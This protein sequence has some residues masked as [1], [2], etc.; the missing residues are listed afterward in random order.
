MGVISRTST[1][2][3][4]FNST[5]SKRPPIIDIM[6]DRQI[7]KLPKTVFYCSKC[8]N[9][10][11]RPRLQFDENRVCDACN[12]SYVKDHLI[13]WKKREEELLRLLDKYRSKDGSY[14]VLVPCSGGKDSGYVAHQLKHVYG[15]HPLTVTWT[16]HLYTDIGWKNLQAFIE[17]GFDNILYRPNGIIHR[18]ISRLALELLGDHFEGW[19]YGANAYP[20]HMALKLN[21]PLVFYGENQPAEYGGSVADKNRSRDDFSDIIHIQYKGQGGIGMLLEEGLK[22]GYFTEEEI[23]KNAAALKY[24]KL[25]LLEE[26][27]RAGVVKHWF[28][29]YRK[30]TPQKNYYYAQKHTGFQPNPDGRSEGT[31]SK[32]ASLDDKTDGFHFYMQFIKFTFGRC[33][34]EAA[35]EIRCGHITREEAVALV[36]KY[37]GEFPRLYFKEYLDYFDLSEEDFW[38]IVDKFHTPH[39]WGKVNGTWRPKYQVE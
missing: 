37:D 7:E 6:L 24:Y 15:M 25:P 8:V 19:G 2:P 12:Y 29:Y 36:R 23:K 16:P 11:Q 34:S 14:D 32:Y 35:M 1:L 17:S 4:L 30:W 26:L 10:N 33:T 22:Y 20:Q 31:Y 13:D 38:R 18:K 27:E 39:L 28:S 5:T 21:I 3:P 9:P